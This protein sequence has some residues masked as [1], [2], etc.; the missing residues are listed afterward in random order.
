[1]ENIIWKQGNPS[2]I[3]PFLFL[4]DYEPELLTNGV[5]LDIREEPSPLPNAEERQEK[6]GYV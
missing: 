5:N 1:M 6:D 3:T 2:P 4:A